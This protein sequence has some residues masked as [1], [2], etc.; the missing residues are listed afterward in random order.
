MV[1]RLRGRRGKEQRAR[2]LART[3][4][5]CEHCLA[6]E[7]KR[8][9]IATVVNHIVP[10]A[11]GGSDEDQNTENLC[12]E[13]DRKTTAKQFNHRYKQPIGVDGWPV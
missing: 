3:S 7:P 6:A 12:G 11:H 4:G 9:A 1:E 2:R 8:I 13:C 5:L 10:L